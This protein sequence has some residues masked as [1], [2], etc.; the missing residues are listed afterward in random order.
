MFII[1]WSG[2][3]GGA[4]GSKNDIRRGIQKREW[5]PKKGFFGIKR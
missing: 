5:E 3:A 2:A 1:S 4:A